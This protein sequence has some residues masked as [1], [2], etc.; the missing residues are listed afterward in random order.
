[1]AVLMMPTK[2]Q[3]NANK[4]PTK[5][6]QNANKMPTKCQQ[7]A[8]KMPTKCHHAN[9]MTTPAAAACLSCKSTTCSEV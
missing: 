4:M 1:V 5:C 2:C 3:Q 7:N 8:N 6:Q 9:R